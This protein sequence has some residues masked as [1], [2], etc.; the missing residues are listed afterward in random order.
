VSLLWILPP[1]HP[2]LVVFERELVVLPRSLLGYHHLHGCATW[3]SPDGTHPRWTERAFSYSLS[4][5]WEDRGPANWVSGLSAPDMVWRACDIHPCLRA[6]DREVQESYMKGPGL[7]LAHFRLVGRVA[8]WDRLSFLTA[9]LSK[10]LAEAATRGGDSVLQIAAGLDLDESVRYATRCPQYLSNAVRP[11]SPSSVPI[12][13]KSFALEPRCW[14]CW[15][16]TSI[17]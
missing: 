7:C 13:S 3:G 11:P 9:A 1:P 8:D 6:P 2:A 12:I 5:G 15:K 10:L 14:I 4:W 16:R 17:S